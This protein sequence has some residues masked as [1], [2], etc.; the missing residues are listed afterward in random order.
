[1]GSWDAYLQAKLELFKNLPPAS[2][3]FINSDDEHA[4][5]FIRASSAPVVTYAV[6]N[7][8]DY[9]ARSI[10]LAPGELDFDLQCGND[11]FHVEAPLIGM[12][13]VYNLAATFAV[14]HHM[15][16]NPEQIL[17]SLKSVPCVRGRAETVPSSAPFTIVVDYAHTPDALAKILSSIAE[18]KPR[19]ILT[20]IGAGGDRDR[21][22]RPEMTKAAERLS[23][24][25]ILTS[26]NPRSEDPATI[27]RD[28]AAGISDP[29][30][31]TIE[32]DRHTAIEIALGDAQA[33]DVVVIAGKGHETYQEIGGK[34]FPFD[35]REIALNWLAQKNL[36]A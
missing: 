15:G 30:K 19:R 17:Q 25:V 36:S 34:R 28:M 5:D 12:F 21:G 31:F 22:K 29:L 10:A 24:K 27:L 26:D 8:A 23:E 35:D 3:A 9:Q 16:C 6:D 7:P 2:I 18:L 32:P 14:A 33:G 1:H 11:S 4:D 13:N 20:V